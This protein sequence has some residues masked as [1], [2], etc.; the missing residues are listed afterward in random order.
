MRTAYTTS[1]LALVAAAT[2][3]LSM[4]ANA[5]LLTQ[6]DQ[7]YIGYVF[8]GQ[9]ANEAFETLRVNSLLDLNAGA[10]QTMCSQIEEFCDRLGS[11]LNIAGFADA[12]NADKTDTGVNTGIDVTGYQYL[13]G[14][15]DG[16]NFGDL[17][18][19]VGGLT[20][21]LDIQSKAGGYGLSHYTLFNGTPTT[22]VPEPATLTLLSLGLLGVGFT[23]RRRRA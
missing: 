18:W 13:L 15:Y 16:P 7:Y 22:R 3:G 9:P 1:A 23:A 14:K 10:S 21:T 19:Y 20:G 2:A 5:L 4:N 17:V 12:T 11:T 8:D 6:N